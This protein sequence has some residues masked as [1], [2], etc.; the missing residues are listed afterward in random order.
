MCRVDMKCARPWRASFHM[1]ITR[2]GSTASGGV[3]RGSPCEDGLHS[4]PSVAIAAV[5]AASAFAQQN[6]L[7]FKQTQGGDGLYHIDVGVSYNF[8]GLPPRPS[9]AGRGNGAGDA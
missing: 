3:R 4:P 1:Q 8:P 7:T 6:T 2:S 9:S 5:A